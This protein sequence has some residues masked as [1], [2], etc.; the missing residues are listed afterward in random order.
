[1][2]YGANQAPTTMHCVGAFCLV[3]LAIALAT[4]CL[5]RGIALDARSQRLRGTA[6]AS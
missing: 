5:E 6:Q 3:G 1:M 2:Q 4:A